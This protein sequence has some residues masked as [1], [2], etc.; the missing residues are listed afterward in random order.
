VEKTKPF[1]KT[2]SDKWNAA[3]KQRAD[4]AVSEANAQLLEYN[5]KVQQYSAML[6]GQAGMTQ[7]EYNAKMA[8]VNA[9]LEAKRRQIS[10]AMDERIKAIEEERTAWH[11]KSTIDKF[12]DE[13]AS[14]MDGA[15]LK[16]KENKANPVK[17]KFTDLTIV[18]SVSTKGFAGVGALI[19]ALLRESQ[20]QGN[21]AAYLGIS[22]PLEG[23]SGHAIAILHEN[24]ADYYHLFDPNFGTYKLETNKLR[25]AVVYIFKDAYPNVPTGNSS[26]NKAYEINGK[27]EGEYT[28][29][30]GMLKPV[31]TPARLLKSTPVTTSVAPQ[32]LAP[33]A[34]T[35]RPQPG[36]SVP[37]KGGSTPVTGQKP[38]V[39]TPT[40]PPKFQPGPAKGGGKVS[41]L[42]SK[43][44]K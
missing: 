17:R 30:E 7:T 5:N 9:A 44:N 43:F 13:F 40:S 8:T 14:T 24:Q 32:T 22:P 23:V 16:L 42:I 33:I 18:K 10:A 34:T 11:S 2:E 38:V 20:F 12:W 37:V 25:E 26:D 15:L 29:F 39:T 31:P 27:V 6:I 1:L 19:D 35:K 36:S 41:D 28:I 21:R 4:A 3:V